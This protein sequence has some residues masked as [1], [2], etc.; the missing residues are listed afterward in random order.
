MK[1]SSWFRFPCSFGIVLLI[2][3]SL[4]GCSAEA[5]KGRLVKRAD[6]YFASGEYEKA[7][8]EYLNALRADATDATVYQKLG[9]IWL[10]QGAPLRAYPFFHKAVEL[11][12]K[13]LALRTKKA[14]TLLMLGQIAEARKEA[15]GMLDEAPGNG[16]GMK[17]LA[18]TSRT[19]EE[20]TETEQRLEKSPDHDSVAYHLATATLALRKRDLPGAESAGQRALAADPKS[21]SAH[22]FRAAM[23]LIQ[24]KK[25]GATEEIKTAAELSPVRSAERL[26]Y[27]SLK[28]Q[29]G[30]LP[31]AK[32]LLEAISKEAPDYVPALRLQAQ[33]AFTEKRYADGLKLIDKALGIDGENLEVRLLQAEIWLAS[34]ETKKAIDSLERVAE[35]YPAPIAKFQLARAYLQDKNMDRAT[36]VLT[37]TIAANHDFTE[38]ILLLAQLDLRSGDASAVATAM[39]NLLQKHPNLPLAQLLLVDAYRVVGR[40]DDAAAI[41]RE[42]IKAFPQAAQPHLLLG[43]ILRQ[44]DKLP[45]AR[46]SFEKALELAPDNLAATNQLIELDL[47][48]KNVTAATEK[49][50]QQLQQSPQAAGVHFLQ[51]KV[52][53]AQ[54]QWDAAEAALQKTL[55][56]DPNFSGAYDMLIS[57]YVQRKKLPQALEQLGNVL[58]KNPA[59]VGGLMLTALI[60]EQLNEYPKARDAYEKLLAVSPDSPV[61]QNNLAYLYG[62]RLNELAKAYELASKARAARSDDP[63]IADTLGWILYKKGDYQQAQALLQESAGKLGENAEVQFHLGMAAYMMG[64]SDAARTALA[65]AANAPNDFPGK[66]EA[67]SRLALLGDPSAP[68]KE[69]TVPE[70]EALLKQ[71]PNDILVRLRLAEAQEKAGAFPKAAAAYEAA[72]QQN[73][74]LLQPYTKLAQLYAGPL[75]DSVKAFDYAKKARELAPNDPKTVAALGGI[76]YQTGNVA[77]AYNLL[78]ESERQLPNDAGLLRN[79]A[80]AAY[81]IGRISE[82]EQTMRKILETAP[83]SSEAEE[84]KTF[85][86]MTDLEKDPQALAAAGP[87]IEEVLKQDPKHTP[88]LMGQAA[89]Q[90]HGGEQKAA[91]GTYTQILKGFPNFAPAQKRLAAIYAD[92]PAN[93]AKAFDLATKARRVLPDDPQLARTLGQLRYQR[94]EYAAAIQLLKESEQAAPLD[95]KGLYYLGM[96]HIGTKQQTEGEDAL[97]RALAAGLEEPLAAKAKQAQAK[98]L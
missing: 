66:E 61:A 38:A 14:E 24:G 88:A 26:N 47:Q 95:A 30:D 77:W 57:L 45:E 50:Q 13:D 31:E 37:Q 51:A 89:L 90:A 4:T 22:S 73:S 75:A 60:H 67:T 65:K 70:L 79:L 8:I 10:E 44:Q 82:A 46:Q 81:G 56:L 83:A 78:Q 55:E 98:P 7:K 86:A 27:A 68:A 63:S 3:L 52:S 16:D 53:V 76:A 40:L 41:I 87:R 96:A 36:A 59:N 32:R 69:L 72:L 9:Q 54:Q 85:L 5:K 48:E 25:E 35:K 62:E 6:A 39:E 80:W 64:Q 97:K 23:H 49:L 71:Q 11:T 74:K 19:P 17:I 43:V 1:R 91:I 2:S 28:A 94:K 29:I 18:D 21:A 33:V 34:G 93:A 92:D 58:A 12:P 84:A 42:Q 20:I 15:V